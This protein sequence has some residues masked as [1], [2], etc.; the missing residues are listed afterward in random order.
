MLST[1][2]Q[3]QPGTSTALLGMALLVALGLA[4]ATG[5]GGRL[6]RS[7]SPQT[8]R[9]NNNSSLREVGEAR[10]LSKGLTRGSL[11]EQ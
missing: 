10:D 9:K 6:L 5:Q 1:A 4:Q 3:Q 2:R 7:L 8:L 11:P